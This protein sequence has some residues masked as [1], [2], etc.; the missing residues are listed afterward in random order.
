MARTSWHLCMCWA[1]CGARRQT[2]LRSELA[3]PGL[4]R[5]KGPRRGAL[6]LGLHACLQDSMQCMQYL[7]RC[8]CV[9]NWQAPGVSDRSR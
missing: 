7:C 5:V 8:S 6:G 9:N 1:A 3:C 2:A 4:G